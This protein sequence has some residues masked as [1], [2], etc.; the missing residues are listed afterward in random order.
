M[1][2]LGLKDW[3]FYRQ[4]LEMQEAARRDLLKGIRCW[5]LTA[6]RRFRHLI[7]TLY[8]ALQKESLKL[9]EE[10]AK[11]ATHLK[12]L[13]EDIDKFNQSYDFGLIAAQMEALDGR[14][15]VISGGLFA[16]EREELST[17]M[18]LKR[19][20]LTPEELPELPGLPPLRD[21]EARLA[22]V[23]ARLCQ[24]GPRL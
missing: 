14:V 15:E 1:A 18:R 19:Q 16:P 22:P 17:R 3:P 9:Q 2:V 20:K 23:L 13:N 11:I 7:Y 5:G 24:E 12:L 6:A 10:Y 21:L 4:F 8:E